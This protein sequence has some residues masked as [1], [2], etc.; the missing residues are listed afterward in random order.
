ML[1]GLAPFMGILL[2]LGIL[3]L[4][5]EYRCNRNA[6]FCENSNLKV[7]SL[8]ARIDMATILFFLGILMAV[9][10]LQETGVLNSFGIWL[11][12]A[13]HGN[14][15]LVTGVI[16]VVSSIV[17]N[18]PL[19]AGCMD[20][21]AIAP[22]GDYGVDGLFWQLLAY[23]AGVGGS[24]LIIGSAAGVVVMGLEK[25]SFGWYLKKFTWIAFIGYIAGI[26]TYAVETLFIH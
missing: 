1:T 10:T 11:N 9:A 26:A 17:D 16:G 8:L 3:W 4:V 12:E 21:Y 7:T 2:A 19:V 14:H 15:Y 20:M 22:S 25:I 6:L 13:S 24:M 23:C 5:S 18:V